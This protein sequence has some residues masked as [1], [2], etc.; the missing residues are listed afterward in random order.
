MASGDTQ[1]ILERVA[2]DHR[3]VSRLLLLAEHAK[4]MS[5]TR[6]LLAHAIRVLSVHAYAEEVALY[7]LYER[8]DVL[9]VDAAGHARKEHLNMK[10]LMAKIETARDDAEVME[11]A[12]HLRQ[13]FD[14]HRRDEEER[15]IPLLMKGVRW[16]EAVEIGKSLDRNK[17]TAPT[18]PHP[19]APDR[20]GLVQKIGA[21]I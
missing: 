8:S 20:G 15:E 2:R 7:P 5:E 12:R 6:R 16:E 10:T 1:T 3:E 13:Q 21:F 4:D 9:G 19:S 17:I 14:A 18:H 11:N